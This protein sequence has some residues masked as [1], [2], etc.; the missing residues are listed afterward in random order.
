MSSGNAVI[1]GGFPDVPADIEAEWNRW[2]EASHIPA[3]LSLPGFIAARRFRAYEGE[4]R[5]VSLYELESPDAVTSDAYRELKR[6]ENAL[7]PSS[8][9]ART[10][11]LPGFARGVYRQVYPDSRYEMP[12]TEYL[13]VVA[14]DVPQGKEDAF[15]AWYNT[16]HIPAMLR[17][18]GFVTARRFELA[19]ISRH[20]G[21]ASTCP[22]FLS[23]YDIESPDAVEN[24]QFLRDRE[25]PWSTWVRSWYTRRLRIKAKQIC[26]LRATTVNRER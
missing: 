19:D 20:H 18:P 17:V 24:E 4:C 2:Y 5:Y 11:A 25:S 6:R 10:L 7:P 21:R 23:L 15:A 16:E 22:R 1:F 8:F 14:H 9:E 13:F 12:D 26:R 3:R